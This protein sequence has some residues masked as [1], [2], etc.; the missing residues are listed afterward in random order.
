MDSKSLAK[1]SND[2]GQNK[3]YTCIILKERLKQRQYVLYGFKCILQSEEEITQWLLSLLENSYENLKYICARLK[4][5]EYPP[6]EEPDYDDKDEVIEVLG[7]PESSIVD[8]IIELDMI[9]NHPKQLSEYY[10]RTGIVRAA[11]F[12]KDIK[13]LY[14]TTFNA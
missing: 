1:I 9:K 11:K 10:K 3:K 6:G 14:K 12:A 2:F 7:I 8:I 13:Q 4:F 5:N